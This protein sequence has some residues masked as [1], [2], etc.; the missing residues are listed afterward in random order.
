M[1]HE[2]VKGGERVNKAN[3]KNPLGLV[4]RFKRMTTAAIIESLK[5][6][7][8]KPLTPELFFKMDIAIKELRRR[9][10]KAYHRFLNDGE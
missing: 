10:I 5:R 8:D 1:D 7:N 4:F 2:E 6:M 3:E 9:D